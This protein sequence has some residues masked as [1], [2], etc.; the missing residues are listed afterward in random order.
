MSESELDWIMPVY[1]INLPSRDERRK[2]IEQQFAGKTEFEVHFIE[3]VSHKV[4]AIGLWESICKVI[5]TAKERDEEIIVICEDD[6][7]FTPAYNKDFFLAQL[8]EASRQNVELLIGGIGGF[9]HAVQVA[10]HRF[11]TDWFYSTQF[12][13][14]FRSFF[15]KVLNYS[16]KEG[17]TADGVFSQLTMDKQTIFPFISVQK[18]FGYSDVTSSNDT[19][20]GLIDHLFYNTEARLNMLYQVAQKFHSQ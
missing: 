14:V 17:D 11:W 3:A 13:V 9:G 18:D 20:R 10:R 19:Y 8:V 12:V 16:F 7:F 5:H 2:H 4:G 15:D 1:V 6:H